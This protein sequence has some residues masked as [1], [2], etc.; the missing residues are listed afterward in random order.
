MSR[1]LLIL[2][3]LLQTGCAAV[4]T[5]T[6]ETADGQKCRVGIYSRREVAGPVALEVDKDCGIKTG[7][8]SLQGGQLS[9]TDAILQGLLQMYL[10]KPADAPQ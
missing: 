10:P 6:H 1:V 7:L 5:Y 3:A 8:Q 9:G 4:Y 2:L